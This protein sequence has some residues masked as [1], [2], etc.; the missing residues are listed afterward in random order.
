M[1]RPVLTLST[2]GAVALAPLL[3][4]VPASVA[5]PNGEG[6]VISEVYGGGGGASSAFRNDYVELHNPTGAAIDLS[7]T[8]VQYRSSGGTANPTGVTALSGSIPAG[9]YYLVALGGGTTGEPL[10]PAQASGSTPMSASAG[11]VFLAGQ[12]TALTAPPTGSVTDHEAIIDLVGYGST[13]TFEKA[14]APAL[15][16]GT[17]AARDVDGSDTDDNSADLAKGQGTPGVAPADDT[18]PTDPPATT[19]A[20]IAEVQGPGSASPLVGQTVVTRGVVTAAY[21]TGGFNGFYLQTAGTGGDVDPA[22]GTASHGVFVFGSGAARAVQVGDH[23]EVTGQVAEF[24]GLT[25]ISPA[26]VDDVEVLSTPAPA[27]QP[28]TVELPRTA[29]E[30]ESLEGMLV[31]PQG[32]FTVADNYT[33]NQYAEIGLAAGTEPLWT[34]TDVADPHDTAAIAAVQA[35]NAARSV[36]LDDGATTNFLGSGE[37]TPLPWLTTQRQIRVGAP[38]TFA[39]PVVLDWRNST[40]KLQ[41]RTQLTA[42]DPAPAGFGE[43]RTPAPEDVG[44]NVKL[45]SFNVLNYFPTT[46][47][48][49]ETTGGDC[50]FYE[51]RSGDPVGVRECEG[52]AGELGPRGAAEQEDFLRQQAKIVAAVNALDADVVSLE[53]IENSALFGKDRDDAVGRLVEALNE[54]TGQSTWDFVPSPPGAQDQQG[55]DVIRTAFIYRRAAV[56]PVGDSVIHDVPTF[57]IARDPLAQAFEPVGGGKYSRFVVVVNHFKSK[58]SGPDDGTGQ[59]NSNPQRVEQSKE[60]VRFADQMKGALGSDKV[61]LAGDFNAYTEEDPMRV[62]YD[63]GYAD[64]GKELVPDEATYLF[65]GAVGSLDHV[66]A[67]DAA[68]ARV[69]GADVWNV[70]S[71][72]SIAFEYSRH[73]YNATDFYAPDQFRASDHDPL[74]AGLDLPLGA[75]PTSTSATVTPDPAEFRT[76]RPTVHV[77]VGSEHGTI[78]GGTVEVWEHGRLLGTAEVVDGHAR[79]VLPTYVKKGPHGVSVRYLGTEDAAASATT[80]YFTVVQT[81]S[82]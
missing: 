12:T 15:D 34:P 63:A 39:Q 29:A 64:L 45:A 7:G 16:A 24:Q 19:P 60:L 31:A 4:A 71:V 61:F 11:T 36:T 52:P 80:A 26:S 58:G 67:N 35:D 44:G 75:V 50:T 77:E 28:A 72:E 78:D 47:E 74:V 65:D 20:T 56:E 55:E 10:P 23:V 42:A 48:E 21:P 30:R 2:A 32:R 9:G 3:V 76:D 43:T 13:N 1:R 53:E 18:D 14:P 5:A 81:K 69:T 62:L 33:L 41:P 17:S 79:V 38:V 68:L 54:A 66:L 22:A 25:E 46:G 73:N 49:F 70:N 8:S 27:V 51:D 6:A 37:N 57:D 82:G 40:W 59:G